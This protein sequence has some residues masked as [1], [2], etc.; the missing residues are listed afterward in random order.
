MS[1][2]VEYPRPPRRRRLQISLAAAPPARPETPLPAALQPHDEGIMLFPK[3]VAGY[4]NGN[5]RPGQASGFISF[6]E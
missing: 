2:G 1:S 5:G 6:Y 4:G 3:S